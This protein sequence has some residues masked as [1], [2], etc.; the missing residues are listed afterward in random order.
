MNGCYCYLS[1]GEV[2]TGSADS[3]KRPTSVDFGINFNASCK[4]VDKIAY[5]LMYEVKLQQNDTHF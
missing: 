1:V 4:T 2:H 3:V 5:W